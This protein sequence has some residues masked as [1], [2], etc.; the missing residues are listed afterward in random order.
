MASELTGA[1]S[2]LR[3]L[4]GGISGL[5]AAPTTPPTSSSSY[6]FYVVRPSAGQWAF[7]DNDDT[8][9]GTHN[10]AIEIHYGL[11]A[12]VTP[13]DESTIEPFG[14]LVK[15]KLMHSSN[16][17]LTNTTNINRNTVTYQYGLLDYGGMPTIGWLIT[18]S[19]E[20][21]SRETSTAFGKAA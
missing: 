3:T 2:A 16:I 13:A 14:D 6:P 20:I 8:V 9:L 4:I 7:S 5:N 10:I 1:L 19:L 21:T 17:N 15:D 11:P 18:F 12:M